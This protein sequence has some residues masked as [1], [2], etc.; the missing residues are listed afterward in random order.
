MNSEFSAYVS[1]IIVVCI[2]SLIALACAQGSLQIAGF[3][4]LFICFGIA[5]LLQWLIFIPSF[6][7]ET[8][9]L[10]DLTGS[11][12]FLI[13]TNIAF[14]FKNQLIN[15]GLDTRSIILVILVSL[16]AV[17][18][19]GFLFI[20]IQRVGEDRRFREWKK[21]F[22]IFFR[23]WTLQ[24]LWVFIT[25]LAALTAI[26]SQKIVEL[27]ITF[28]IGLLFWLFGFGFEIIADIQKSRFRDDKK[29]KNKFIQSGLWSIS[30]H[31]NY[32]GEIILWLGVSIIS[33]PVLESWQ[34]LSLISP[35]FVFFLLTKI[36]GIPIL[37]AHSEKKWGTKEE[38]KIYK[39]NTHLLF[40]R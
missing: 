4:V 13:I 3:P 11:I 17:R 19:G 28:Y 15:T 16:W 27:D 9:H 18:L 21:S 26:S 6:I 38:Y 7:W 39:K 12:T 22:P 31:P 24:G 14:Y 8:E 34:Y 25:S 32:L 23:T 36:S 2:S 1:S 37:E 20:R 33:L 5:F 29:N 10:Y 30:R 35:I 40:P